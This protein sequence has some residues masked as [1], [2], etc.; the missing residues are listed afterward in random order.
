LEGTAAKRFL[1]AVA[2]GLVRVVGY[3]LSNYADAIRAL[4]IYLMYSSMAVAVLTLVDDLE[5]DRAL[6]RRSSTA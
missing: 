1:V 2:L 5:N 4:G 3:V 6:L